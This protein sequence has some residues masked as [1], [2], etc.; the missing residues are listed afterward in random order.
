MKTKKN[1]LQAISE[2]CNQPVPLGLYLLQSTQTGKP[3]K[4]HSV[5][6]ARSDFHQTNEYMVGQGTKSIAQ[7]IKPTTNE[8]RK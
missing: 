6:F 3:Q 7:I 5:L 1:F 8:K 4:Q 2:D